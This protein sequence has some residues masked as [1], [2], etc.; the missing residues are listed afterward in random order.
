M[1]ELEERP[2][3]GRIQSS[4]RWITFELDDNG[5]LH[6]RTLHGLKIVD[7]PK[8]AREILD[9]LKDIVEE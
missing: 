5:K 6:I 1:D 3:T 7:D 9:I 8:Q 2:L 4:I